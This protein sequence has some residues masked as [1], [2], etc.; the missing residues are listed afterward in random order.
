MPLDARQVA[1]ALEALFIAAPG[2]RLRRED[3]QKASELV[4]LLDE[5]AR[6]AGSAGGVLVDAAAGKSVVGLL[7]AELVLAGR[8][9]PWRV[10]VI[11]RDAGRAAACR[12]AAARRQRGRCELDV[13]LGEVGEPSLWPAA[14]ELVV[15]L[16][17]CGAASDAVLDRAVASG[18]RRLLLVPCCYGAAARRSRAA[19]SLVPPATAQPLARR[20]AARL[21][22][23]HGHVGRRFAQAVIDA[24]RTLRLEASGYQTEVVELFSPQV[25]PFNL[26]WRARRVCEPGR[27]RAAAEQRAA[28]LGAAS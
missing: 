25:S 24:E 8:R 21:A 19:S 16:H 28:L 10:V 18:A 6:A 12:E 15:A 7:A 9:R 1:A 27:M 26:L 17:A 14:P 20:L 22:I 23:P 13:R 2:T 11:E 4:P 3:Q 5:V